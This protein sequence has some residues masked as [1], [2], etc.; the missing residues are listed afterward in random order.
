MWGGNDEKD[1]VQAVLKALD[2]GIST[3]DTAP[4]YGFG[5]SEELVGKA[6]QEFGNRDKVILATKCGLEWTE[7]GKVFRNSSRERVKKEAEDSLKRLKTDYHDILQI[8]W[9]DHNTDFRETA[10]A[11][12]E[13]LK[14]GKIRSIGVS[15]F[16]PEQMD[17]F[18]EEAPIHFSQPPY[19]LF[20]RE[21]EEDLFPYCKEKEISLLTYGALCRG[22]LT[23][24]MSEDS[25]FEG[26]DLRKKDPKFQGE[27]FKQYLKAV[28]ALD[29]Y[30]RQN[31][32]KNVLAL[33][34]RW[35]LDVGVESAI[36]GARRP[37]QV[38]GQ[39]IMGWQ[40][41]EKDLENIDQIIRDN[42]KDPVGPEFM[43]P[44]A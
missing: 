13:L 34:A 26:D 3:I 41:S 11:M 18:R 4:V 43:A 5:K 44:P 23:G 40:L 6:I 31:H 27:R 37:D 35:I 30:A 10:A 17:T 8:H 9:P 16:S 36:W 19:N 39:E 21:I 15:N 33:A 29:D 1:S 25:T 20:E 22:L 2:E 28:N 7:K 12:K 32:G 14:E 24:K 38:K 42:V